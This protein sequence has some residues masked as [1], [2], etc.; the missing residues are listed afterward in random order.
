MNLL[1]FTDFKISPTKGG[2]EHTTLTVVKQLE[3]NHDC[4]CWAC[5]FNDVQGG[6]PDMDCFEKQYALSFINTKEDLRSIIIENHI[7]AV[8]S[9]EGMQITI[10]ADEIRKEE[11]ISFKNIFV[12]H[13]TPG[14]EIHFGN[15]IDF[16]ENVKKKHGFRKVKSFVKYLLYPYY[17][18]KDRIEWPKLYKDTY[19]SADDVVLLTKGYIPL[20]QKYGRFSD[21]RKFKVIPNALSLPDILDKNEYDNFKKK[22]VV[23]IARL[24][25]I[26]KR[27][28]L[29]LKIWEKVSKDKRSEGWNLLIGGDGLYKSKYEKYVREHKIPHIEFLGR[30]NPVPY[31]REASI[32]MMTSRSE[33]FPLTL[34]EALQYGVVPLAF[35]SFESVHDILKNGE[36]GYIIPELDLKKYADNLLE[37]MSNDKLRKKMAMRG[38]DSCERY[39]PYRIGEMWWNLINSKD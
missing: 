23:V 19:Y 36:N 30:I 10:Y 29:V 34:N 11:N 1:F 5:H 33:G 6:T 16:W 3:H 27:I 21:D 37:L 12:H 9:E 25:E 7:E 39:M 28:S 2:T 32:F 15:K 4:K 38:I 24:E 17:K 26:Q 14:W 20:Y 31:Y 18:F 8:L 22:E 35:D 13:F